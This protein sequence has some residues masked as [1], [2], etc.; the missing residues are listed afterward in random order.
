MILLEALVLALMLSL[1]TGGSLRNLEHERL[2]GE[3]Y[4]LIL[5]PLQIAWP[6]LAMIGDIGCALSLSVW[7]LMMVS[8]VAVL[9]VNVR[10]RWVLSIAAAGIALNVLVIGLNG[11]MPV[12]MRSVSEIGALRVDALASLETDCLHE[13]LDAETRLASLADVIA[14]PGPAWRRGVISAGDLLLALGLGAWVF[15]GTRKHSG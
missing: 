7:L 11:A 8:L 2:L 14:V 10:K 13:L 4:L 1:V 15:V 3:R 12:S 6:R 5:L 9:M